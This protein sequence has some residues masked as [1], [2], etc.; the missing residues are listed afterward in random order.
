MG[1]DTGRSGR[2]LDPI[3]CVLTQLE[4]RIGF[5]SRLASRLGV[6]PRS[7]SDGVVDERAIVRVRELD[8]D[9]VV[10]RESS[11][12]FAKHLKQIRRWCSVGVRIDDLLVVGRGQG[13][14]D[15]RAGVATI[16]RRIDVS[17]T[18]VEEQV[19]SDGCATG[20][21]DGVPI[22]IVERTALPANQQVFGEPDWQLRRRRERIVLLE[23]VRA[24]AVLRTRTIFVGEQIVADSRVLRRDH[25]HEIGR[26]S[27]RCGDVERLV[28]RRRVCRLKQRRAGRVVELEVEV[29]LTVVEV[30]K[31]FRSGT[32]RNNDAVPVFVAFALVQTA[33]DRLEVESGSCRR[34]IVVLEAIIGACRSRRDVDVHAVRRDRRR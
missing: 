31:H 13:V 14:A 29:G 21:R 6:R 1:F 27:G 5:G 24:D 8:V 19:D 20:H 12:T 33:I 34:G 23:E 32:V 17:E 9:L 3:L 18:V 4:R 10:A 22:T 7:G 26:V 30:R 15:R 28:I 2:Q 25:F 11:R 16:E